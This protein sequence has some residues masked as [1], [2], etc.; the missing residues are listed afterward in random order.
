MAAEEYQQALQGD[1]H[2]VPALLAMG[3][4]AFQ[5]NRL[6]EAEEWFAQVLDI[7]HL[8]PSAANNL[9]MV[10][11]EQE[12]NLKKA[13]DLAETALERAGDLRPYVLDTLA[14]IYLK[15]TRLLAARNALH[16][17]EESIGQA[18]RPLRARLEQLRKELD[19]HDSQ[20]VWNRSKIV[21]FPAVRRFPSPRSFHLFECQPGSTMADPEDH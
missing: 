20:P 19:G 21:P 6:Q 9:A 2:F 16:R 18:R 1:H 8:N 4:L 11:L 14:R 7:D 3:N 5:Q 10:Y 13:E 12:R 17:A 15:Q